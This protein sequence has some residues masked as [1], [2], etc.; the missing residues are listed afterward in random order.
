MGEIATRI[1]LRFRFRIRADRG[2]SV[3]AQ[4]VDDA[5][6]EHAA[7]APTLRVK[8]AESKATGSTRLLNLRTFTFLVRTVPTEVPLLSTE[9]LQTTMRVDYYINKY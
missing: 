5:Q 2:F 9:V 8:T 4:R 3:T 1:L 6:I 7:E